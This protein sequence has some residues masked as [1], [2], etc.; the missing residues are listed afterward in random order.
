MTQ[1]IDEQLLPVIQ[2]NNLEVQYDSEKGA[3]VLSQ[4]EE[5]LQTLDVLD[6]KVDKYVYQPD[7]RKSV[8]TLK[9]QINKFSASFKNESK[10]IQSQ[11]FDT[12]KAQEK[13]ITSRLNSLVTKVSKGID[14]EDKRYKREKLESFKNEFDEAK[15]YYDDLKDSS[16]EYD[17]VANSKWL[18]RSYSEN[19]AIT[20]MN[21]RMKTL[22][23]LMDSSEQYEFDLLTGLRTLYKNDWD[24][25]AA[26][27]SLKSEHANRLREQREAY[28]AE[29]QRLAELKERENNPS[30]EIEEEKAPQETV[31][32]EIL[33]SDLALVKRILKKRD[34]YFKILD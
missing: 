16:L 29:Q 24:G 18:N 30:T 34:V 2:N 4:Y 11:L 3:Y 33:E 7:D 1:S 28:E 9:A 12:F 14:E 31:S 5:F 6:D 15:K 23:T 8:K 32:I 27:N 19:K 17:D 22:D 26:L 13:E 25:L 10:E 20:E 21:D